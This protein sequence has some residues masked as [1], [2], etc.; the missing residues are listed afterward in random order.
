MFFADSHRIRD[1]KGNKFIPASHFIL[2]ST[3]VHTEAE[4]WS[5]DMSL[6]PKPPNR[7]SFTGECDQIFSIRLRLDGDYLVVELSYPKEQR[8]TSLYWLNSAQILKASSTVD[9]F[10]PDIATRYSL[11]HKPFCTCS[12]LIED[13]NECLAEDNQQSSVISK[14][15]TAVSNLFV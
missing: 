1:P 7:S 3:D 10:F 11:T 5:M 9:S 8:A 14:I 4:S 2:Q 13:E 15:Q 6:G 12:S